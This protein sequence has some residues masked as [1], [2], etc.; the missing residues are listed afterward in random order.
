MRA[1]FASAP[2]QEYIPFSDREP[3]TGMR[4]DIIGIQFRDS[5][6]HG[7]PSSRRFK[8]CRVRAMMHRFSKTGSASSDFWYSSRARSCSPQTPDPGRVVMIFGFLVALSLA[9]QP[10]SLAKNSSMHGELPAKRDSGHTS[11][12]MSYILRFLWNAT[13]GHR[14]TPGVALTCCGGSKTYCGVRCSRWFPEFWE[15]MWRERHNLWHFR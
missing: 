6:C 1:L 3:T 7:N 2:P 15:F 14:L 8:S 4:Q 9:I 5:V 12:G 11:S 10:E 13:R